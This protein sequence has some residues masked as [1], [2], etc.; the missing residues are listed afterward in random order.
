MTKQLELIRTRTVVVERA[1]KRG[2]LRWPVAV[3]ALTLILNARM[4]ISSEPIVSISAPLIEFVELRAKCVPTQVAHRD[5]TYIL[6]NL[7]GWF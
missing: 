7:P 3:F 1:Q 4:I 5:A 6:H 2:A